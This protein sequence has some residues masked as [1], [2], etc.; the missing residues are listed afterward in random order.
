MNAS[1]IQLW[2]SITDKFDALK[3]RE[4][5][6]VFGALL[7]VVYVAINALLLEPVL[8]QKKSLTNAISADEAQV[9]VLRQQLAQ[10]AGQ[11]A[12]DPDAKNKQRIVV[13]QSNLL[14]L[15][16]QLNSLQTTLI[17]PDKIPELLRSLLKEN[18]KLKL[19]ELKTLTTTGLL[20]NIATNDT[21]T[22]PAIASQTPN[23]MA[24]SS[25]AISPTSEKYIA[26]VF[27]HGVEITIEGRYL[28]LLAY[29][30]ELERS[31]WHILWSKAALNTDTGPTYEW[32]SNR[33]KL[34]VY[35]LSLDQTWLSI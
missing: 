1:L 19:I 26:P 23:A 34:T 9:Q 33:L 12:I 30:S 20:D 25:T 11:N 10:Y 31:P 3:P 22:S 7:V 27:K 13:L 14:S 5:W 24:T 15:E 35:T 32:P 4:R 21:N 18:G 16:S 2:A 6:L 17:Q 29:V 28:D 8:L